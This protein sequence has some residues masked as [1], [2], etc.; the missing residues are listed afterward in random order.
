MRWMVCSITAST[1]RPRSTFNTGR[2]M[3]FSWSL[4]DACEQSPDRIACKSIPCT[5]RAYKH[6]A[7]SYSARR[8]HR[9]ASSR[10]SGWP[11]PRV[12][13]WVCSG[14]LNG[15][16]RRIL[17]PARC[18]PHS[19]RPAGGAHRFQGDFMASTIQQ[20]L[21]EHGISEVEAIIPDMAEVAR[22]KLMP[23]EKSAKEEGMPL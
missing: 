3:K 5:G 21:K 15:S 11:S 19:E 17:F 4:E 8:V 16:S 9:T 20:F 6:W 22:A 2:R 1:N 12:L 18:L 7:R 10:R 14:I 23:A 13:R